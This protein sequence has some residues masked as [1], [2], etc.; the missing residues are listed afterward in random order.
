MCSGCAGDYEY[1]ETEEDDMDRNQ[2]QQEA[3]AKR[4]AWLGVRDH[5]TEALRLLEVVND[6]Q[7]TQA[8]LST[9]IERAEIQA[10]LWADPNAGGTDDAGRVVDPNE[11]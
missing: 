3:R 10:K 7:V 1:D 2:S 5:L 6:G 8:Q 9:L 4:D 11:R